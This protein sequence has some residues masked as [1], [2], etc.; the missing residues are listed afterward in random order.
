MDGNPIPNLLW[1]HK[2]N[3]LGSFLFHPRRQ[4]NGSFSSTQDIKLKLSILYQFTGIKCAQNSD[5]EKEI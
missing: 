4:A 5:L 2:G 1:S 3:T